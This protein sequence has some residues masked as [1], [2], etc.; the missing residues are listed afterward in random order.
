MN[1]TRNKG[2]ENKNSRRSSRKSKS[3]IIVRT[4]TGIQ[5]VENDEVIANAMYKRE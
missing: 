5:I 3:K 4:M 2:A 1:R